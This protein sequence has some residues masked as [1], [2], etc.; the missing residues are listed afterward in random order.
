[1]RVLT[2]LDGIAV[3]LVDNLVKDDK[4][5]SPLGVVSR[6]IVLLGREDVVDERV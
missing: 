5:S 2:L 1:M 6:E 4:D 3:K